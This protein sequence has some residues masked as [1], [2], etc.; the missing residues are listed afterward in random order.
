M[1]NIEE[2]IIIEEKYKQDKTHNKI[3]P[4]LP[5]LSNCGYSSLEEY[6]RDKAVYV[7]KHLTWNIVEEP[8]IDTVFA[9]QADSNQINAFMYTIHDGNKYAFV[10][11]SSHNEPLLENYGFTVVNIEYMANNGLILSFDGD[12]RVYIVIPRSVFDG[13]N[14]QFFL[15]KINDYLIS[16]GANSV[17]NNNDILIDNKKV[18]G[19]ASFQTPTS[20]HMVFQITF[21]DNIELIKEIC[22]KRY[23]EPSYI[24]SDICTPEDML[25]EMLSWL[26]I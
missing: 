25:N 1:G 17:I 14:T 20:V 23:K 5:L 19:S 15:G 10:P 16:L 6:Q 22:G 9:K 26:R 11:N 21:T 4:I 3:Y 7:C 8:Y 24:P 12:L 2:A 13:I 18:C